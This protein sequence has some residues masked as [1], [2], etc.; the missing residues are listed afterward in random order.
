MTMNITGIIG[1]ID[2]AFRYRAMSDDIS[3]KKSM[4]TGLTLTGS[5]IAETVEN[6]NRAAKDLTEKVSFSYNE[7]TNSIIVKFLDRENNEVV[8]EYP[9]KDLMKVAEHIHEYLGILVDETR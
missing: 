7:K 4:E 8:R 2:N 9:P 3:G 5:E 6:L 1:T